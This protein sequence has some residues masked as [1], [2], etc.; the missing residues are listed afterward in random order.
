LA[1]DDRVI[2]GGMLGNDLTHEAGEGVGQQGY[3]GVSELQVQAGES[4]SAG[5]GRVC[6][7]LLVVSS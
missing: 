6:D 1:Y 5:R 4:V 3:A 7:E 2:A